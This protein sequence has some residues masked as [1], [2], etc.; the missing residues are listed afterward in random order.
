MVIQQLFNYVDAFGSEGFENPH[1]EFDLI[2]TYPPLYLDSKRK[3]LLSSV[4]A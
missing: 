3:D 1:G 2:Q 4:F